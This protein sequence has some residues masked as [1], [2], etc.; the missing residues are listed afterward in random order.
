MRSLLNIIKA[1]QVDAEI[2]PAKEKEDV[3]PPAD[4]AELPTVPEVTPQEQHHAIVNDALNKAKNIVEA[5]QNY[6]LQQLRDSAVRMNEECAQRKLQG[7][8]Q[9]FVQ[10]EKEGK[11]K[12]RDDGYTE[13]YAQGAKQARQEVQATLD[14]LTQMIGVV[15]QKG[16]ELF[17]RYESDLQSLAVAIAQKIIR[18]ELIEDPSAIRSILQSVLS[19]YRDVA[20][21][22][23]TVSEGTAA[24]MA[25]MEPGIVKA[26]QEVSKNIKIAGSPNM[27]EGDCVIDL[28]DRRIDAG[29]DSQMSRVKMVLG[30]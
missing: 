21:V 30:L 20:W 13:G 7:Y 8:R 23:I 19:A 24:K 29:I 26:L 17:A 15:E 14:E 11:L 18:R 5:A 16:S 12:G 22:T 4:P 27:K 25:E 9:G 28:P 3:R 2:L 1:S 6:S 10:G